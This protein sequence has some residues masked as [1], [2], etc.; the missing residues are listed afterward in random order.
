MI[1]MKKLF[2]IIFLSFWVISAYSQSADVITNLLESKTVTAGQMA[3]ISACHQSL[4]NDSASFEDA[5]Q[6]LKNAGQ[7]SDDVENDSVVKLDFVA[8]M[9]AKMWNVKGGLFYTITKGSSRY[10]FKQLK[11]DGVIPQS[12]DPKTKISGTQALNLYTKCCIVYGKM[13]LN[14]DE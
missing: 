11:A 3:Y 9:Y 6:A 1:V 13:E 2:T 8:A 5:L 14:T 12:W 10:A 4:V 7:L